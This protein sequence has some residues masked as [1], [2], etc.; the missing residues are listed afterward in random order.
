MEDD[1]HIID[2]FSAITLRYTKTR[3][4]AI[5][6][7][8]HNFMTEFFFFILLLEFCE[9]LLISSNLAHIAKRKRAREKKKENELNVSWVEWS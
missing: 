5:T 7:D 9:N 8:W 1:L 4:T 3:Q 6:F 2:E